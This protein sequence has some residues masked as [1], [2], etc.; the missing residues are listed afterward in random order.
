[1][2]MN[3]S[4]D[5]D[6]GR[7]GIA[8]NLSRAGDHIELLAHFDLLAVVAV[9]GADLSKTSNFALRP[10]RISIRSATAA[11]LSSWSTPSVHELVDKEKFGYPG[12]KPAGSGHQLSKDPAYQPQWPVY[13]ILTQAVEVRLNQDEHAALRGL[14]AWGGYG[15][16]PGDVLRYL[17]F[18]WCVDQFMETNALARRKRRIDL[19]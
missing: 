11:E 7:L 6:T 12:V 8:N 18:G 13:P 10:L 19:R 16:T 5:P 9:C 17:F 2:W 4:V 14:A 3:T 15:P 1:M